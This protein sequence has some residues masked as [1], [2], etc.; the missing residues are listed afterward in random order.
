[1]VTP[2][3]TG[4]FAIPKK[5]PSH[6]LETLIMDIGELST[7][8]ELN[9]RTRLTRWDVFAYLTRRGYDIL[10]LQRRTGR[11]IR[12]DV[13]TSQR[14]Y[15]TSKRPR[16]PVHFTVTQSCHTGCDYVLAFWLERRMVFVVPK[17]KLHRAKSG[18][19][20]LYKFIVSVR[21]NRRLH[22]GVVGSYA[23]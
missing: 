1:L 7:L 16:G 21:K 19:K 15:T 8:V 23:D 12:D 10:L 13:K 3:G 22:L 5:K 17:N 2:D 14:L 9:L 18:S 20:R 4:E 6:N 11:R